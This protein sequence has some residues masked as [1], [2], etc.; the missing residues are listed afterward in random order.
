MTDQII[1]ISLRKSYYE[2]YLRF[3]FDTPEGPIP[4]IRTEAVGKY[5]FSRLRYSPTPVHQNHP[6]HQVEIILPKNGSC[7]APSHFPYFTVEDTL[8]IND[9]INASSYLDFRLIVNTGCNDL[10]MD[11]KRVIG[12][13]SD[14]IF[15][16]DKYEM[17]KKDDYRRRQKVTKW[18]H[19]SAKT[20]GY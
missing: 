17:L 5:I 3:V 9:F 2:N 6:G 8:F 7:S 11:R 19:Q 4:I 12:L 15:G 16:E 18:L 1:K 14:L 20:L 10:N 13:Y